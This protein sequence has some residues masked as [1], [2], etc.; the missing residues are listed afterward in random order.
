MPRTFVIL[1][2]LGDPQLGRALSAKWAEVG[3][4]NSVDV[5]GQ[6][7]SLATPSEMALDESQIE[8]AAAIARTFGID[9]RDREGKQYAPQND[10]DGLRSRTKRE[11]RSRLATAVVFGAPA[12]ALHYAAP[13]LAGAD[14]SPR[15]LLYPW[16]IEMLLVGWLCL[17]GGYPILWQGAL[18][19][20]YL[21]ATPDLL[22]LLIVAGAFVPSAI[23]WLSL[24]FADEPWIRESLLHVAALAIVLALLQR[25]ILHGSVSGIGGRADVMIPNLGR[26]IRLWLV[27][28]LGAFLFSGLSAIVGL[29]AA[30]LLPP[31]IGHGAINRYSPGASMVLPVFA[32]AAVLLLGPRVLGVEIGEVAIEVAVGFQLI[33]VAVM[34]VGW[35]RFDLDASKKQAPDG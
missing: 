8:L 21:R 11:Y 2:G 5:A 34:A 25:R 3:I 18:S 9:L 7:A 23:G 24:L 17:A 10:L 30:L 28:A 33:M 15:G 27:V 22:T 31:M 29:A 32:F 20:R 14:A 4:I 16:L 13:L 19:L 12:V 26:L 1:D 6:W 35:R